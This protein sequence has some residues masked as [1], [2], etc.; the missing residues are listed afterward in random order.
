MPR[1]VVDDL[2]VRKVEK[3][4]GRSISKIYLIRHEG[5]NRLFRLRDQKDRDYLLKIYSSDND[6]RLQREYEGITFLRKEGFENIPIPY[7][8]DSIANWAL[9]SF[10][11]GK[12][13]SVFKLS[14]KEID[15]IVG[16]LV[17]VH[18]ILPS[19]YNNQFRSANFA[20]FSIRDYLNNISFRLEK[21]TKFAKSEQSP[22]VV[23]QIYKQKIIEKING[24]V[25][26]S[27]IN[28][29]ENDINKKLR[30]N[31]VRLNPGDF[32]IQNMLLKPNM[33]ICFLDLEYFGL[34]DPLRGVAGFLMHD[35][36]MGIPNNLK[37]YF[38][39][40]Y[41]SK[42]K[43]Y[44]SQKQRFVLIKKL[45]AIEWLSIYLYS[46]TP[47]KLKIRGFSDSDFNYSEYLKKQLDK[48]RV[49]LSNLEK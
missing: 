46:S 44:E 27:I 6:R 36:S 30:T 45:I 14:E 13:I 26:Q 10:E 15:R 1:L 32:S 12:K 29:S 48:F 28:W 41:F 9:Y 25:Q 47:D 21:F 18:K 17:N 31:E 33:E 39:D 35:K 34:D 2:I 8:R 16:F 4:L 42:M 7:L 23:K 20:C 24:L 11:H 3:N 37:M 49:R 38:E 5:N 43:I 22:Y 40:M 19:K